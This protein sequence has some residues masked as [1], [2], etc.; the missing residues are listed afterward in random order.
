MRNFTSTNRGGRV[1][2]K[3]SI[4]GEIIKVGSEML[5]GVMAYETNMAAV[6]AMPFLM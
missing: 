6:E 4:N 2:L 1:K 3:K 5:E